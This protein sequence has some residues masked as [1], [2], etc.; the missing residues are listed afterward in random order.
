VLRAGL[1]SLHGVASRFCIVAPAACRPCSADPDASIIAVC[2]LG[3]E[4]SM[5]ESSI[6]QRVCCAVSLRGC[7]ELRGRNEKASF[8]ISALRAALNTSRESHSEIFCNGKT[9]V[10]QI[11]AMTPVL[12]KTENG[13]TTCS[14][15]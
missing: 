3:N 11:P 15:N 8:R 7:N 4:R 12:S 13:K 2:V 5:F 1:L 9:I 10:A 6:E 14:I